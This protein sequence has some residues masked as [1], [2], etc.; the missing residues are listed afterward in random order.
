MAKKKD[1]L[2][3]YIWPQVVEESSSRWNPVLEVTLNAGKYHLNRVNTN[4][5]FG[6]PFNVRKI[7][8]APQIP[9]GKNQLFTVG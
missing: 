4:Y 2:L 9:P 8:R 6:S 1:L 5:S 7:F 3:S